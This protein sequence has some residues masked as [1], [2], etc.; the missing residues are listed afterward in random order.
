[1]ASIYLNFLAFAHMRVLRDRVGHH[2][3]LEARSIDSRQSRSREDAVGEYG[4]N[5]R[6]SSLEQLFCRVRNRATRI[7]HVVDKDGD[8][9]L[10]VADQHHGGDLISLLSLFVD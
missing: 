9:V 7:G 1:M 3:S 10:G 2:D 5:F 8:T 6:G 4:V